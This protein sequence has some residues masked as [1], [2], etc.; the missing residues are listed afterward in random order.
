MNTPGGNTVSAAEQA[1]A[2]LFALARNIPAAD[3][4]MKQQV[5]EKKKYTGTELTGK[6]LGIV[7]LG[8][9]GSEVARRAL[10]LRMNVIGSPKCRAAQGLSF[11]VLEVT[12]AG[13]A[14]TSRPGWP[15]RP[16]GHEPYHAGVLASS[17]GCSGTV[18]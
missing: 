3:A 10:G 5:W 2:M 12:R 13:R 16:A 8:R 7:G 17:V 14:A 18:L 15:R 9:I 1:L 6:T 11:R 4:S